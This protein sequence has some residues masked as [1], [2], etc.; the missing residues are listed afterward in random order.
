MRVADVQCFAGGM[1]LGAVQAGLELVTKAEHDGGFGV[2]QCEANRHLL[3]HDWDVQ[4]GHADTWQARQAEIVISN[5]PCAGFSVLSNPAFRGMDSKINSCMWD[6]VRYAAKVAPEIY[7]M[8]SVRSAFSKGLPLMRKLRDE[9]ERLTGFKYDLHH[10]L[11]DNYS[12]GGCSKRPRYFMVCSRVPFGVEPPK[13]N[14]VPTVADAIGDLLNQ[15]LSMEA[16]EYDAPATWW[17]LP[18]RRDDNLVDGHETMPEGDNHLVIDLIREDNDLWVEGE[19]EGLAARNYYEKY[20][21]FPERWLKKKRK[22]IA[23]GEVRTLDRWA[24][25]KNFDFGMFQVSR[26]RWNKPAFV[27]TGAGPLI[28]IHPKLPR[29]FTHREIARIMGFPDSWLIEPLRNEKTLQNGWGKG[30]SVHCGEWISTWAKRSIEGN[31]G[32]FEEGRRV[33]SLVKDVEDVEREYLHDVSKN[34]KTADNAAEVSKR[35]PKRVAANLEPLVA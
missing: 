9:L 27:V 5:P 35:E 1:T 19:S 26:W 4:V 3:G 11:Q 7:V 25:D 16:N 32:L 18:L 21:T 30:V 22:T 33:S 13:L 31:P 12:L 14:E 20:G 6:A 2:A 15:P 23:T 34:W 8:E 17:S 28:G 10:V 24:L 29:F